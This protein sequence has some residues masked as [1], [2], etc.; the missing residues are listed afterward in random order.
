MEAES[1]G[2][3]ARPSPLAFL[4]ADRSGK[5]RILGAQVAAGQPAESAISSQEHT[6]GLRR[7]VAALSSHLP[8]SLRQEVAARARGQRRVSPPSQREVHYVSCPDDVLECTLGALEDADC[9]GDPLERGAEVLETLEVLFM[10]QMA[11]LDKI[12]ELKEVGA[13]AWLGSGT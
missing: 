2:G 12:T 10:N 6:D 13:G 8:F 4:Q 7:G 9:E 5:G 1:S 11:V 3:R